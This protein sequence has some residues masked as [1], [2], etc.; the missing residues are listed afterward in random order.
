MIFIAIFMMKNIIFIRLLYKEW[1]K[2]HDYDGFS[3][4][5]VMMSS[6]KKKMRFS[7]D[8]LH[9]VVGYS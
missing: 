6:H 7:I 9:V 1:L 8:S 5:R 4:P 3:A 2:G